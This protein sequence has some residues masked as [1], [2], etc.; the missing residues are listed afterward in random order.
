ML[1]STEKENLELAPLFG[2]ILG[3]GNRISV[4]SSDNVLQAAKAAALF[5]SSFATGDVLLNLD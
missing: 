5:P 1:V 2:S 4:S 3:A